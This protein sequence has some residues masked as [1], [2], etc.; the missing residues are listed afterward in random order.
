MHGQKKYKRYARAKEII[1][2][3]PI[4]I[5]SDFFISIYYERFSNL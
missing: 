2:D 5:E 3:F 1:C 4:N